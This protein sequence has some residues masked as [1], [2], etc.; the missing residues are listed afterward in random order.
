[1]EKDMEI[2]NIT[3]GDLQDEILAPIIFEVNRE[4][5]TKRMKNDEFM[6]ILAMYNI[7]LFQNFEDFL[8]T[9]F[10]LVENDIRLVLDDYNSSF[11]TDD[12]EPGVYSLKDISEALLRNLQPEYEKYHD[13]IDIEFDDITMKTKLDLR[14]GII[15]ISFDE[16]SFFSAMLGFNPHWA[17]ENYNEYIIQKLI[18]LTTT[19]GIHLKCDVI[20]G[21]VVNGLRQPILYSFFVD[22]LSSY[23]VFSEPETIYYRK[24]NKTVSNT[25]TFYVEGD[26]H[27]ESLSTQKR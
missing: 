4:Q 27:E 5:L 2:E 26:N 15:A 20:D 6:R 11:V 9:E 16:K 7:Y 1:M 14:S 25:I 18:K 3:A 17:F 21:S 23:R 24:I 10:D 19:T 22:K 8:R 12:L 13:A